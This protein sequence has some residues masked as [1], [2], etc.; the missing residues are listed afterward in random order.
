MNLEFLNNLIAVCLGLGLQFMVRWADARLEAEKDNKPMPGLFGYVA[1]VPAQIGVALFA[2]ASVFW[3]AYLM[4]WM[5]PGTSFAAGYMGN[6][7][8]AAIAN[9]YANGNGKKG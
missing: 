4:E 1:S 7:M 2:T 8:A 9:R 3:L 6:D 5:N